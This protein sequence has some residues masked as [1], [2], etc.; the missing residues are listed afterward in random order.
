ME[1]EVERA[2]DPSA[3]AMNTRD[4]Q[5]CWPEVGGRG[6]GPGGQRLPSINI[7]GE[8]ETNLAKIL[9]HVAT[10]YGRCIGHRAKTRAGSPL[11]RREIEG[12]DSP[13]CQG[14]ADT[15]MN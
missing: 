6:R 9:Q 11:R 12:W 7:W 15:E 8:K 4:S 5:E 13:V 10:G 3:G 2:V 14:H 1:I